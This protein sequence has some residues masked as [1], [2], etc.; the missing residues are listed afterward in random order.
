MGYNKFITYG[1]TVETFYYE[2]PLPVRH[3]QR[4]IHKVR[5]VPPGLVDDAS[6]TLRQE[7]FTVKRKDN[8]RRAS[9]VF[10]RL[11]MANLGGSANPLLLTLTYRDNQEDLHVGYHDFGSFIQSLRHKFGTSFRY[12]AVPE[13]QKRGAVHFHA[14]VWGLPESVYQEERHTRLV[15]GLW[16][17]GFVY[18]KETDGHEK[19]SSYLTKYMAKSFIDYRLK[20][21]KAYVCSKNM[22][23][24]VIES[25]LSNFAMSIMSED[26]GIDKMK[27]TKEK[28]YETK[29]LGKA[30]HK[31]YTL[32]YP[33]A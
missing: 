8:A 33:L 13:F 23:R 14:L 26:W 3:G 9:V 10:R 28:S 22:K 17:H 18:M 19:L 24:P 27:P 20:N 5:D 12:I 7:E 25:G 6:D 2:R 11:V 16:K 29:W 31:T 30:D 1:N 21:Q 4:R 15:A 32:P